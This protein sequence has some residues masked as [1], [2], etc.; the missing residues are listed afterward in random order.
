MAWARVQGSGAASGTGTTAT[1]TL[2]ATPTSG[3]LLVAWVFF[4]TSTGATGPA[5]WTGLGNQSDA[6]V[7]A[8]TSGELWYKVAGA[9]E[10]T[11]YSWTLPSSV[12][13][14]AGIEEWSGGHATPLDVE[15]SGRNSTTTSFT[16][17]TAVNPTDNKE[18]LVVLGFGSRAAAT[19]SGHAVGGASA[20]ERWDAQNTIGASLATYTFTTAAA[21]T[22]QGTATASTSTTG[23]GA[24]AMF[25]E[26]NLKTLAA[27]PSLAVA[28][29][30]RLTALWSLKASP[31]LAVSVTPAVRGGTVFMQASPSVALAVSPRLSAVF[32]M[33][34]AP[35]L[36]L[37]ATTLLRADTGP[38]MF[39]EVAF[40]TNPAATP[41]WE[42]VTDYVREL[43]IRRG[44]SS[45]LDRDEAGTMTLVLD[46]SSRRFDPDYSGGPYYGSI[47]PMRR[48][49]ARVWQGG[50]TYTLFTGYVEAWPQRYV[51]ENVAFVEVQCVDAFKVL[52]L[53]SLSTSFA[54][55]LSS[56]RVANVLNAISWPASDRSLSTGL[57]TMIAVELENVTAKAHLDSVTESENG[58]LFI[59]ASGRVV[60]HSRHTQGNSPYTTVQ[61]ALTESGSYRYHG[62]E[63][64][65]DDTYVW[66]DV[67]AQR[68]DGVEQQATDTTSIARYYPRGLTR[69]GLLVPTD[70]EALAA[71]QFLRNRYAEPAT[72]PLNVTLLPGT[73]SGALWP[74]A[75]GL[76]LGDRI[77]VTRTPPGGGSAVTYEAF[78]EGIQHD[79]E[80]GLQA[81]RTVWTLSPVGIGQTIG[82]FWVLDDA[83]YSVLGTTTRWSY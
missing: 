71:A 80:P 43:S 60:F 81:W 36:A 7:G 67:R 65:Y 17:G 11:S 22:Y 6:G 82:P 63:L 45:E 18:M 25:V 21:T 31:A 62:L 20:T 44:R 73:K 40:T 24:I 15:T 23:V 64:S 58:R 32:G 10:S 68:E 70:N 72:R 39:V 74:Y 38:Q 76:E 79:V 1:V 19:W 54:A 83:T 57:S 48:V 49:R 47:R 14:I 9:S 50:T 34:A 37:G 8:Q 13:W 77:S 59:D 46:N 5:G 61:V 53:A 30:P 69:S 52:S 16:T 29:T 2:S 75:L 78:I 28:A 12:V 66:N 55:E 26:T 56:T 35:A 3:N 42:S 41:V 4:K 27:T 51:G 33:R